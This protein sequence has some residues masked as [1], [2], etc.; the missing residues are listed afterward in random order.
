M[1]LHCEFIDIA[2]LGIGQKSSDKLKKLGLL[3]PHDLFFYFPR[4]YEN[5]K[6]IVSIAEL[7][8]SGS[9]QNDFF[10]IKGTLLGIANKKTRRRGFTVTEAVVADE[11]GSIKVIWFN[12]PYLAKMLQSGREIIL[13]GRAQY[14][15]FSKSLVMQSPTRALKQEIV[16]VYSVTAGITTFFISKLFSKVQNCIKEI[17]E[18]LPSDILSQYGLM[19]MAQALLAVHLPKDDKELMNAKRRLAFDEL[20]CI[21]LQGA[22]SRKLRYLQK[23]PVLNLDLDLLKALIQKLPFTLTDD[24]K[25]AIWQIMKDIRDE[26]PMHRLLN[27]DVGSGKTIVAALA[28]Y[29]CAKSG[30]RALLMV[31]TEILA[32]Q[33]YETFQNILKDSGLSVGLVTSSRKLRIDSDILIGTHSLIQEGFKI[34]RVGLVI[35]DEQHRFGV[36]QRELLKKKTEVEE[37]VPH[38]LSMTATPIPRTLHLALFGELDISLIKQKPALRKPVQTRHVKPYDRDK[39]YDFVRQ[40]ISNGRQAFVIC[41]LIDEKDRDLTKPDLFDEE[42]KSVMSEFDRLEKIFPEFKISILHGKMKAEEKAR[43]MSGFSLGK[44]NILVSTSVVEVGV[45]IPNASVML[46][47]DAER[48]G[49]AQIHQFRGRVGRGEHQSYCFLFSNSNSEK[50]LSR[51]QLLEKI[52]DG[53]ALAEEDLKMRGPGAIFGVDQSGILDLKMASFSDRGLIL[54][55]STAAAEIANK[56]D[57][58]PK[59]QEHLATTFLNKH[60]E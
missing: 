3:T 26:K 37:L 29:I 28:S 21:S 47:E 16:P 20:F 22:I 38:F 48:F 59:V 51:L 46:V 15:P 39:A 19:P 44:I 58:C 5:Y 4:G 14:D 36:K 43:V 12:Q 40:Q 31:P 24:Q 9:A 23:S 1:N 2:G 10:T 57:Q 7:K 13:Y 60:M 35:V 50:S 49:L 11:S 32:N 42:R 33:H 6:N 25:R 45:D 55:A 52:D 18:W 56:I 54:E 53:F 17:E 27:G 34:G 30:Y 41:P 8:P